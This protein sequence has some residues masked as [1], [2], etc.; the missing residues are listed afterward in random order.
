MTEIILVRHG[1]ANTHATDE[2]DYDRLSELGRAQATWLGA[3]LRGTD[4]HFDRVVTG[5]LSRQIETARAMGYEVTAQD[6]R[7]NELTYFAL[8]QAVQ[9]QFGLAAPRDAS[10]FAR[11]LPEVIEHWA[12][13]RLNGVP[14]TFQSFSTRV[15]VLLD[16]IS[17]AHGRVLLVTSGGV[18]GMVL[19]HVLRLDNAGMAKVMLQVL[20]SSLHR[21]HFV[22]GQLM[23]GSFNATPH[24]DPP[25]RAHART[26]V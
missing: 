19:R 24:L 1:Q 11:H 9:T 13:D 18:I 8:A 16:E 15:S 25:D 17:G 5:T 3:H 6:P 7:L 26:F 12:E 14:E 4:P 23:L 21:V 22:H 10:E 2:A 20:N